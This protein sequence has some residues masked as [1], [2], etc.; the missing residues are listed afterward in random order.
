MRCAPA[1]L[2]KVR[3]AGRARHQMRRRMRQQNYNPR[4][5]IGRAASKV[6]PTRKLTSEEEA[7]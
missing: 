2:A 4:K 7:L 5:R 6:V 3:I 1:D